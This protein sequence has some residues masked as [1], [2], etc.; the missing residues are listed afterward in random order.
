[1]SPAR[2]S[3]WKT[4]AAASV[5]TV[6]SGAMLI[7]AVAAP[8]L[9]RA[10]WSLAGWLAWGGILVLLAVAGGC[11]TLVVCGGLIGLRRDALEAR[12]VPYVPRRPRE[13]LPGPAGGAASR[14]LRRFRERGLGDSRRLSLRPGELVE[15]RSLEDILATLD[16]RGTSGGLPFMP[17]MAAFCGRRLRVFRRVDKINDWVG[18]TG[19]RRPRDTVMLERLS[20]TGMH[21]GGCQANCQLR[22]NEAWLKRADA[23][24]DGHTARSAREARARSGTRLTEA[25]LQRLAHRQDEA[26][27]TRYMCQVTELA[28]GTAPLRRNDPR[29]Y[30]RDL[31]WGNVRPGPLLISVCIAAFNGVQRLRGGVGVPSYAIMPQPTSPHETLALQPGDVVRV[32]P[33]RAIEPTLNAKSRNRGLWFD[34]EML[35]YCG[36]TYRVL[37][38]VERLIEERTGKMLHLA[39]PCIILDG[40]T[41]S[42]EYQGLCAQNESIFWREIWLERV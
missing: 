12:G 30:L 38:R 25:D 24:K 37:A 27:E 42:G 9:A 10:S 32:K 23:G 41:A 35:R 16:E 13:W 21:H 40:V 22:W 15:V 18:H 39:S 28:A 3:Y 19:L 4:I 11:A 17:E 5:V 14:I 29:H 34:A 33:K 2:S 6:G 1:V 31:W 7:A 20:C 8:W 26:G 36:G